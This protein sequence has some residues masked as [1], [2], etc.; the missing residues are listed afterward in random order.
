MGCSVSAMDIGRLQS[1]RPVRDDF[2]MRLVFHPPTR[3]T[4][5]LL[6]QRNSIRSQ[7]LWNLPGNVRNV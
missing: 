3:F 2:S 4:H 6:Q 5:V 7:S 1:P